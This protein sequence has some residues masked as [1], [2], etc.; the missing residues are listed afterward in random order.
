MDDEDFGTTTVFDNPDTF[1]P[2]FGGNTESPPGFDTSGWD[3]AAAAGGVQGGTGIADQSNNGLDINQIL[4][5]LAKGGG[6]SGTGGSSLLQTL[7]SLGSGIYGLSQANS[8]QNLGKTAI[9]QSDPFGSQ[10][11]QYQQQLASLMANPSSA[12][13]DPGYTAARDQG[14]Q[15]VSRTM[16]GQ[17]YL[18]S[19]NEAIALDQYGT[20]FANNYI[21]QQEQLLSQLAGS[22]IAPNPAPG[23]A[24][25]NNGI[26]TAGSALASLGYG[27]TRAAPPPAS[28]GTPVNPSAAG[29]EAATAGRATSLVGNLSQGTALGNVANEATDL[30]GIYSGIQKGGVGGV[31]Q[32]ASSTADLTKRTG[33]L[34]PGQA[35]ILSDVGAGASIVG[36]IQQGGTKGTGLAIGAAGTLAS[37]LGLIGGETGNL[38]SLA[39]NIVGGNAAGAIRSGI[40]LYQ[41]ATAT[42]GATTAEAAAQSTAAQAGATSASATAGD[43][44]GGALASAVPIFLA[45]ELATGLVNSSSD[46]GALAQRTAWGTESNLNSSLEGWLGSN[47]TPAL[48]SVSGD[49]SAKYPIMYTLADGTQL[50]GDQWSNLVGM[51]SKMNNPYNTGTSYTA[52]Q[53]QQY[54]SGLPKTT[55]PPARATVSGPQTS[56]LTNDQQHQLLAGY[57]QYRPGG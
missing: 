48:S 47:G 43:A 39:G 1:Q 9:A 24:A 8:L 13:S 22:N 46:P 38:I 41:G 57:A 34:D 20:S 18:G 7:L 16:A 55:P 35:G 15:A 37:N 27:A 5:T 45:T 10:R 54:L 12:L 2:A 3:A 6:A 36:G 30:L 52:P 11:P 50:N 29:G 49:G 21:T 4:A 23:L 51:Y 42:A 28:Y 26:N 14:L 56:G 33:V 19:G 17:G 53:L 44:V 31:G 40:G 32:I 25:F